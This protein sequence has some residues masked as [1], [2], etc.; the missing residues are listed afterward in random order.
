MFLT[1]RG[2][3]WRFLRRRMRKDFG[4]C[5]HPLERDK[6]ILIAPGLK[7]ELELEVI[8]HELLH[9]AFWDMSEQAI[10]EAGQDVARALWRIGYR[11]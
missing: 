5:E 3:R 1:I 9:A 2:K 10:L 11:K 4:R 8:V 6:A 7:H